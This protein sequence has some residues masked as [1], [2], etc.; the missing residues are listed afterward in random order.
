ML[1]GDLS[2][3]ESTGKFSILVTTLKIMRKLPVEKNPTNVSNLE[4][5]MQIIIV[6]SVQNSNMDYYTKLSIC[7]V[8]QWLILKEDFWTINFYAFF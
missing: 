2:S 3:M 4:N 6:K 7:D 5:W 1:G 8:Y